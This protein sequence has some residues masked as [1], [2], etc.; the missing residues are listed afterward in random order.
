VVPDQLLSRQVDPTPPNQP[1]ALF[2]VLFVV[3]IT[4][5]LVHCLLRALNRPR[6]NL[7]R[8]TGSP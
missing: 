2:A 8:L 6:V 7:G 4:Q 1:T 3:L 5:Y